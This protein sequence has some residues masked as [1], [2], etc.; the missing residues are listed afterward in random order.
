M[1]LAR[2]LNGLILG[3]SSHI[4]FGASVLAASQS[5]HLNMIKQEAQGP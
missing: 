4:N 3:D 1:V 5:L 2:V